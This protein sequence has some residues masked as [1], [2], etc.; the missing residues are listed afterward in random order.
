MSFEQSDDAR[1]ERQRR[2]R[3]ARERFRKAFQE[4]MALPAGRLVVHEFLRLAC[5][6]G[7]PMRFDASGRTDP[8]TTAHAIGWQDGGR[9]WEAAIRE[10]CPEREAQMRNEARRDAREA[11][12]DPDDENEDA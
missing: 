8:Q 4:V 5:V 10:H 3:L 11:G 12:A 1:R 9:W 6:D 2:E 7:T